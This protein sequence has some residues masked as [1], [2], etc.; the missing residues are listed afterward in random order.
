VPGYCRLPVW[1][2]VYSGCPCPF[3]W[4]YRFL[5]QAMVVMGPGMT[6]LR[7]PHLSYRVLWFYLL[8]LCL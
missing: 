1:R 6:L 3:L 2:L 5:L 4:Q 7:P 8:V